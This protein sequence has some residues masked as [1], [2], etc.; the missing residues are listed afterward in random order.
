MTFFENEFAVFILIFSLE[1]CGENVEFYIKMCIHWI[2]FWL[3]Q[4]YEHLKSK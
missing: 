2:Y 3:K 4:N 1:K